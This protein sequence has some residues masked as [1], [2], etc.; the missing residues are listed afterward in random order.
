MDA[1]HGSGRLISG[2]LVESVANAMGIALYAMFIAIIVPPAKS[3]DPSSLRSCWPCALMVLMQAVPVFA[4]ISEGFRV[5]IA[6]ILA[7]GAAAFLFPVREEAANEA[8]GE[9]AE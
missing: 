1:G 7:A 5:I 4:G 2:L 3:R 8:G 9:A 6:T